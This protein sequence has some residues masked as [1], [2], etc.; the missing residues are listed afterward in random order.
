MEETMDVATI[1]EPLAESKIP[2]NPLEGLAER[3]AADPGAPFEAE[4]LQH[5]AKLKIED[6]RSFEAL[7]ARLKRVGVRVAALDQAIAK[8]S[9]EGSQRGSPQA[10]VLVKLAA[11]IELFHTPDGTAF[12]DVE[13]NDHRETWA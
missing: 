11:A 10:D 1:Y 8:Q 13:I 12:A 9:Y 5:L 2:A 4:M 6:P 7:R 3:A